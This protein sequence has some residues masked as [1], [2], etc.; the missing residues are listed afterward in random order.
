MQVWQFRYNR[1]HL[2]PKF[3]CQGGIS[4]ELEFNILA[5]E[6]TNGPIQRLFVTSGYDV[7]VE[8]ADHLVNNCRS[9][10]FTIVDF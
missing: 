7:L 6:Q 9:L 2:M 10:F 4:I 1:K 3:E 8:I 5:A